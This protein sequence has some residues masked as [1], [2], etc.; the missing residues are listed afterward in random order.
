MNKE[1]VW[2]SRILSS[3]LVLLLCLTANMP[4]IATVILFSAQCVLHIAQFIKEL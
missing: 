4:V 2:V 3:I 1:L